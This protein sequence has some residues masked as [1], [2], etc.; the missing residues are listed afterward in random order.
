[1][2]FDPVQDYID[3]IEKGYVEGKKYVVEDGKYKTIKVDI[4]VGTKIKKAI[5]RHQREVELS[6]TPD[7]PYIYRPEEALPVIRFMEMLPEPKSRKPMKLATF[8]KFII[9]LL[10]G[11]RK[12]R[13]YK[14][15]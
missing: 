8:Q 2:K 7:Y 15:F 13:Q 14:T 4:R 5:E 11:W 1:M 9:G 10:Y 6:K 3:L 12:K